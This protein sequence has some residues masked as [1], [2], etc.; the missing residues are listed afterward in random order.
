MN[1]ESNTTVKEFILLG[2]HV[3]QKLQWFLFCVFFFMYTSTITGNTI[4]II[5]IWQ[6]SKLHSP[7]YLFLGN[8]SFM[9]MCYSSVTMPKMLTDLASGNKEISVIGCVTQLYFFFVLGAIENYFLAVMAYDRYLAICNPLRYLAIMSNRFCHQLVLITWLVSFTGSFVPMYLL[10][11]LSFCGRNE[12][13]NFFC[14]ASPIF[15]LSCTN[16]SVLKSYF[17]ILVWIIVFSCLL[18]IILSYLHI[19]LVILKI[20]SNNGR[21][22]VFST[23]GSHFTVVILY[24]G[25]VISM[26]IRPN[27]G[28]TFVFD[29]CLSVFYA[30]VTPFLN[31]II[32]SLRNKS[33][34]EAIKLY[35]WSHWKEHIL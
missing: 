29:K 26:Y 17:F 30:I 28:Y 10:S 32:Y 4:I 19:I 33:I 11:K 25:S 31:P 24:Y 9:E 20:P 6:T 7:M 35:K 16:T 13:D 22:K 23:C 27:H 14:D 5:V 34:R 12:I 1:I 18:F 15:N 2:F 3:E 21:R 8:F